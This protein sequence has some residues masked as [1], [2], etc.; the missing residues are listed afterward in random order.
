[1]RRGERDM[2]DAGT[3]GADAYFHCRANCEAS[4]RGL[5]GYKAAKDLSWLRETLQNEPLADRTRDEA[6]N[7]QGRRAGRAKD[8]A[9]CSGEDN[10]DVDCYKACSHLI[11]PWG[12][13]QRHLPPNADPRHIYQPGK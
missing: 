9:A 10:P 2:E 8:E 1:M 6:A 12:I 5:G 4:K 7:E 11:P 3:L 13:P